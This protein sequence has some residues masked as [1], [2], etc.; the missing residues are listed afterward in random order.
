MMLKIRG[1]SNAE[2]L[3]MGVNRFGHCPTARVELN[4]PGSPWR[5]AGGGFQLERVVAERESAREGTV[6]TRES[7]SAQL[8]PFPRRAA[9]REQ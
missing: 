9:T 5:G 2:N 3:L 1:I 6:L 7:S 4:P 8:G